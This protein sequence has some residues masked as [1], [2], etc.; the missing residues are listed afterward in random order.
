M[1]RF[2]GSPALSPF[3]LEKLRAALRQRIAAVADICAESVHFVDGR[4]SSHAR[5]LPDRLLHC[6]PTATS[7]HP[8]PPQRLPGTAWPG[9]VAAGGEVGLGIAGFPTSQA[10]GGYHFPATGRSPWMPKLPT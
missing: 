8:R 10:S 5:E 1:L 6:R 7:R 3:R 9:R 4:L 2:R